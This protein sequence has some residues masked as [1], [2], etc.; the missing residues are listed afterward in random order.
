MFDEIYKSDVEICSG[1]L[2]FLFFFLFSILSFRNLDEFGETGSSSFVYWGA[3]GY[4]NFLI[5]SWSFFDFFFSFPPSLAKKKGT[6]MPKSPT[7]E[8]HPPQPPLP[9]S[10]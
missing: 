6:L 8:K 10:F 5:A 2:F 9:E 7:P 3:P 4:M 1:L